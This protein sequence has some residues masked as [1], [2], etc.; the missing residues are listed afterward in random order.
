MGATKQ[1]GIFVTQAGV[2][3]P[4]AADYQYVF[5]SNW[6]SLQIAF[7]TKID[8]P[9]GQKL[10]IPHGLKFYPLT[11]AWTILNGVCI[12][13]TFAAS[14][15]LSSPQ[16]DVKLTFDNT[17]V[18]LDN[19]APVYNTTTYTMSVKCYNVDI[20]TAVDYT[21]PQYPVVSTPYDPTYGIKVVKYGE[22][23]GNT[24]LR[25]FILHSR[26]Q[27]PAVL[28]IVTKATK[29]STAPLTGSVI[30]YKNPAGYTPWV[31]AFYGGPDAST[32]YTPIAPGAQQTGYEFVLQ[33]PYGQL[34]SLGGSPSGS[35]VALRDPLVVPN[36][37]RVV[38]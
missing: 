1:P 5:N 14:G 24:D 17:N 21:L 27:S 28:S 13:R 22:S 30:Q 26:A 16:N 10:T 9:Y 34:A 3:A 36:T 12:G 15:N 8:V 23:I 6:P 19:T 7:E 31:L 38:Y 37:L 11:M 32:V 29:D 20:S 33:G 35:V 4:Y 25:K 2:S 18:Y